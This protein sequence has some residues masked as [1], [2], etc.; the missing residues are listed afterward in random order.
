MLGL[1]V[2]TEREKPIAAEGGTPLARGFLSVTPVNIVNELPDYSNGSRGP[3]IP[4]PETPSEIKAGI[5]K[6]TS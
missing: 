2:M 5:S 4:S 3:L 6:S 1:C